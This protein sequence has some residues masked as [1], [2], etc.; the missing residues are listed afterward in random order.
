MLKEKNEKE[1]QKQLAIRH[2][3]GLDDPACPPGH[4]LLPEPERLEHLTKIKK[5]S[6]STLN[7]LYKQ[8]MYQINYVFID[9]SRLI[10]Q[11]N[12]LPLSSDSYKMIEKRK[13]IERELDKVQLG[14]KLFSRE[15]LF[16]KVNKAIANSHE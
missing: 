15:K 13:H 4:I 2:E 6:S 9:Y 10:M 3:L 1:I 14:I 7:C 11:L 16:V 12:M 5:G 8:I